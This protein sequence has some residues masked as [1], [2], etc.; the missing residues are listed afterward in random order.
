MPLKVP[1]HAAG[2]MQPQ[3]APSVFA[4]KKLVLDLKS[5]HFNYLIKL[6]THLKSKYCCLL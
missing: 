3:I 4:V 6:G 2:P 1:P 5:K